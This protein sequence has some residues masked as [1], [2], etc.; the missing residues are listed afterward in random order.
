MIRVYGTKIGSGSWARVTHGVLSGL[1]ESESLAGF[2]E[3]GRVDDF[4]PSRAS[5]DS[6]GYDASVGVA[7]GPHTVS[8]LMK[9]F[10]N[11]NSRLMVVATNSSWL[12]RFYPELTEVTAYA[13]TSSWAAEVVAAHVPS[14]PV[15]IWR[16][17]VD[18]AF[19]PPDLVREPGDELKVLHLASTHLERKGTTELIHGWCRA[20][21][22][23]PL[24]GELHLL[25]DGPRGFFDRAIHQASKGDPVLVE[26]IKMVTRKGLGVQDM[27]SYL[28]GFDLVCQPS[29]AEGFGLVP[30]EARACGVPVAATLCTG[31]ADHMAASDAG[32]VPIRHGDLAPVNDGPG[33][34]APSVA[35]DDIAEALCSAFSSRERLKEESINAAHGVRYN[36]SWESV[37][38]DF[39]RRHANEISLV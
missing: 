4:S 32:V 10:G 29:R 14:F 3:I 16:H 1:Q 8:S 6:S 38:R 19:C 39:L 27:A 17:G 33:A 11:H 28:G 37:T 36:W 5:G 18:A 2:F 35:P 12:P 34:M 7:V 21:R 13:A 25:V 9:G 15:L 20:V 22:D 31:H 23:G 30:L 26:T 24:R